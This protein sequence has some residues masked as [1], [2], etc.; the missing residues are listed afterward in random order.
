MSAMKAPYPNKSSTDETLAYAIANRSACLYHLDDMTHAMADA[1]LA[2]SLGY[3]D[4]LKY[5]LFERIAKCYL[6][7]RDFD[8][9]KPVVKDAQ[10]YLEKYKDSLNQKKYKSAAKSLAELS[11]CCVN[12][13]F[14]DEIAALDKESN[15]VVVP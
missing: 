2:L 11:K 10:R 12:C 14:V 4:Q 7:L 15:G 3:P 8:K 9:A 1:R 13:E 5:K 6:H